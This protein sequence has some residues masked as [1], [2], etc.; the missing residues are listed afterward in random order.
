MP[1]L[2]P[3]DDR[4]DFQQELLA[5]RKD[6]EVR[7]LA[8]RK[9]GDQ[10]LAEDALQTAFCAVASVANPTAIRDLRA[11]F[12]RVLIHEVYR[13]RGQLGATLMEDF[14][15]VADARQGW[16]GGNLPA[17]RPVAETVSTRL[18]AEAW[19]EPFVTRRR[20]LANRV[21]GRSPDRHRYREVI[22]DVAGRVLCRIITEEISDADYNAALSTA[23]PEWFD[24][25]GS[26]ENNRHQRF[27]RA[28]EDIRALLRTIVNPDDLR[29]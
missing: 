2:N 23:Y 9:A 1:N 3:P 6:P 21:P 8:R 26:A 13:L 25:P 27:R 19:M 7:K 11:Y 17:R 10:E 22:V 28:R 18:L 29:P 20:E 4:P 14:T 5:I 24:Q 12:C 15:R 16:S